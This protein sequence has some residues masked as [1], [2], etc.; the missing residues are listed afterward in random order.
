MNW[1]SNS[2]AFSSLVGYVI[3]VSNSEVKKG[4]YISHPDIKIGAE[5][6][7]PSAFVVA[8]TPCDFAKE[9][10]S[11][12]EDKPRRFKLADAGREITDNG[13]SWHARLGNFPSRIIAAG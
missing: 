3:Q 1:F 2:F 10:L 6:L 9:A 12:F 4:K 8:G 11:L 13:Y 5:G 7:D